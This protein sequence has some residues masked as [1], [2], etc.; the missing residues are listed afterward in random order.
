MILSSVCL[1]VWVYD[2][3]L[4]LP[5]SYR[6]PFVMLEVAGLGTRPLALRLACHLLVFFVWT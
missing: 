6:F 1:G 5:L 2:D 4:F 3:F